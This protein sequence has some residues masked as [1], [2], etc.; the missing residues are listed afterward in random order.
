M[1]VRV[2]V[3]ADDFGLTARV[4][5]GV[6]EAHTRGILTSAS[7]M[8]VGQAFEHAAR[9]ARATP[10]LDV[11]VHLTLVEERPLL[12]RYQIPSLVG[13]EGRFPRHADRF[14]L[15]YFAGRINLLEVRQELAEQ[16]RRGL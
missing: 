16:C 14:V 6:L 10:A 15:R 4:N 8:A 1:A 3:N 11:G 13:P 5:Q 7:I 12:P 2:I 9:L